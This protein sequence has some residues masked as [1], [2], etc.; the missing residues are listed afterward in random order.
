MSTSQLAAS[1][2]SHCPQSGLVETG[3]AGLMLFRS[4]K[5]VP[6]IPVVYEPSICFVASGFKQI[7]MGDKSL[8]YD[9]FRY[10][11]NSLTFP[12][13]ME[14]PEASPQQP[15][16]GLAI[17]IDAATVGQLMVEMDNHPDWQ[18]PSSGEG[19]INTAPMDDTLLATFQRLLDLIDKPMDRDIL[20]AG[21]VRDL[22]FQVLKG[23]QGELLRNCVSSH[24]G[25][26]RI[27][28]VVHFIEQNYHR[29]LDIDTLSDVASMSASSLHEHFKGVTSMAPMQFVKH[30]RLHKARTLLVSGTSASEASH[31]VGYASPSQFSREFK[32]LFGDLPSQVTA[33]Y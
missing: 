26:T 5:P 14:I 11:V 13:E 20:S 30:L 32:R 21:L 18:L 10:L 4:D 8:R 33:V 7:Y 1:I 16:L 25:A 6:R 9:P 17:N 15:Y 23:P 29:S 27:A 28:P 3:I 31:A 12:I 19:I 2:A 22:F 24:S